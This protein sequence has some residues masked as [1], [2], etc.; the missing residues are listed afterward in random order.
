MSDV[1]PRTE[2]VVRFLGEQDGPPERQLKD[3][4]RPMLAGTKSV[5]SAYLTQVSYGS[6]TDRA[7]ALCLVS[8]A[9][10]HLVQAVAAEFARLFGTSAH[11]D[12]MFL[13]P[14]Q[15]AEC[16]RVCPAFYEAG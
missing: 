14:A 12:I 2:G 3:A 15:E 6:S 11:L 9:S 10:Q 13:E 4:L 5:R 8:P 7:V 1:E 16:K